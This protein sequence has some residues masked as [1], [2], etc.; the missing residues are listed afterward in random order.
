MSASVMLGAAMPVA[1]A[2]TWRHHHILS[3]FAR[4]PHLVPACRIMYMDTWSHQNYILT[5]EVSQIR[6]EKRASGFSVYAGVS[7]DCAA[8][9]WRG[10]MWRFSPI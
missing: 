2:V 8:F 7:R 9:F 5:R 1:S 4:T 6:L 10:W 3:A